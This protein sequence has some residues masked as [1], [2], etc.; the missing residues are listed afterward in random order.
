MNGCLCPLLRRKTAFGF[1]IIEQ[2]VCWIHCNG[3]GGC[4]R[5]DLYCERE[6]SGRRLAP[7]GVQLVLLIALEGSLCL[8][9]I[10]LLQ[11]MLT[12]IFHPYLQA[13]SAQLNQHLLC[14]IQN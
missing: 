11:S 9:T 12:L 1:V 6:T 10:S 7:Q 5:D 13:V 2:N 4:K 3:A 8:E 14:I